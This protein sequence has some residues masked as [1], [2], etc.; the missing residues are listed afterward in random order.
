VNN[1]DVELLLAGFTDDVVY[2]GPGAAPILGKDA[3]REYITPIYAEA[4]IDIGM[5]SEA[6]D[7]SVDRAVE[8]GTSHGEMN[9]GE[10]GPSK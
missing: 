7:V 6:L 4:S 9:L 5:K 2:I 10:M 8:W 3:M 1:T